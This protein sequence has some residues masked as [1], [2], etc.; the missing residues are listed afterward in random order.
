MGIE[1]I[2]P[3]ASVYFVG[4]KGTGVCAL[5]ELMHNSGLLISGSDTGETFYTDA[6]LKQLNI[7]YYENFDAAHISANI[8]IVIHSAAYSAD[9]N[10]ELARALELGI[11]VM[12]YPD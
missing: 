12:K 5:A 7:P 11:P 9:S 6:I 3:G 8:D 4:I 1:K 10:P 2:K